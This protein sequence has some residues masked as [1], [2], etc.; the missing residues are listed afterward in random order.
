MRIELL[1]FPGCPLTPQLR[2]NAQAAL[3]L[4][5][6]RWVLDEVNQETLASGDLRRGW[7]APTLLANGRD[8]FGMPT[9]AVPAMGCRM[10]EGGVPSPE[11]IAER[12]RTLKDGDRV[13]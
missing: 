4:V 5:P 11:R 12:L 10:Y 7:P 9:P 8:L 3:L 2:A 1:G 13:E 6:E